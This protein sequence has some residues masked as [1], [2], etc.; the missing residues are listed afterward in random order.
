ML[1]LTRKDTLRAYIINLLKVVSYISGGTSDGLYLYSG[2]LNE[3]TVSICLI[4]ERSLL[5]GRCQTECW[6]RRCAG[7]SNFGLRLRN[8]LF[9]TFDS[10]KA[11]LPGL[12]GNCLGRNS[13]GAAFGQAFR[14][15]HSSG[16]RSSR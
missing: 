11:G 1:A 15:Q 3:V 4:S 8:G 5:M 12:K 9:S 14:E 13:K 2:D 10:P 16:R 6:W 7:P